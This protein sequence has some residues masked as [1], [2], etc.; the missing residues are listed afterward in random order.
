[1]NPKLI[2]CDLDGTLTESK[3]NMTERMGKVISKVLEHTFFAVVSGASYKQFEKQFLPYLSCRTELLSKLYLFP[4]NGSSCFIFEDGRWKSK[5]VEK[6]SGSEIEQIM[7]SFDKAIKASGIDVSFP[8]GDLIENRGSQVTF[9]GRGQRAPLEEKKAWDPDQTKRQKIVSLLIPLLP[10]FEV[11][12]GGATSIDVTRKGIDK[13]YA[14]HKAEQLLNLLPEQIIF[15]GDALF[16]AGND[17]TAIKAK[18]WCMQVN[19]PTD[20]E[21]ELLGIIGEKSI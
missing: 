2:M 7:I 12:I 20:T 15:F 21:N 8:H 9:S 5:Y 1:M 11:R 13:A 17:A 3:T 6:L 10:D 14:I 4:T 19:G 18:V 16:L